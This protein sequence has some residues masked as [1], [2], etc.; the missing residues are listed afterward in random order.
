M[1]SLNRQPPLIAAFFFICGQKWLADAPLCCSSPWLT[2]TLGKYLEI[3]SGRVL[4]TWTVKLHN[5]HAFAA[6]P[7]TTCRW[8]LVATAPEQAHL[9]LYTL[10]NLLIIRITGDFQWQLLHGVLAISTLVHWLDLVVSVAY[11]FWGEGGKDSFPCLSGLPRY[12]AT[13][14]SSGTLFD[15]WI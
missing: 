4:Y 13:L 5:V 7:D 14:L 10:Y 11:L 9:V 15:T 12:I 8:H 2:R 6:C 3:L 1:T